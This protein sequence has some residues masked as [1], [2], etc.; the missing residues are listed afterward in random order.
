MRFLRS[1]GLAAALLVAPAVAAAQVG[2]IVGDW[3]GTL[4]VGPTKLPLVFH[5]KPDGSGSIDSPAQRAMGMPATA[6]Y[7]D[8]KVRLVLIAPA[9]V[10]EGRISTDAGTLTGQWLQGGASLPL[11][12]SRTP[13][14]VAPAKRPQTPRPP[15]PYRAEEVS[16]VNPASGLKLAGTLT[17]PQGEG[18]FPA[19]VLITGSGAQDRDETIYEHKPFLVL[20]DAL[21][22]RG[23]AVLR[24]DD[25][26]VGGSEAGDLRTATSADFATDVAAGVAFL[27]ARKDIDAGRVGL[28]GHS[29]GGVIAPMVAAE[30]PKIAFLVLMAGTG[31]PGGEV[32]KTQ[33]RDLALANGVPAA[34]AEEQARLVADANA[35][36]L[37]EAD[38]GKVRPRVVA[39]FTERGAPQSMAELQGRLFSSAWYK[40]FLTLDPAVYLRRVRA[41][42][43]ALN[44]EK[45]LQVSAAENL[46]AIRAALAGDRD[47][48]VLALPGLNHLFQTAGTGSP[49]EYVEIEETITPSA[50][51]TIVDWTV[52]RAAKA[53]H[54][55]A[56]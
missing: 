2:P 5:V 27:R 3:Y 46:P 53:P 56:D 47:V 37:G 1:A 21:T 17:L 24:V 55:H 36:V 15:F 13:P 45:D 9:A 33:A 14:A 54:K 16:Y 19:A 44:G 10:F 34:K 29:E 8:G 25:R 52:A 40:A 7:A 43:L 41:P 35:V 6:S 22:R 38:P 39:L 48:T 50:L 20:A 42:V 11:T 18:P 28:I 26:G 31:L 12:L 51:A 23:V 30:D 32:L 49:L 4:A